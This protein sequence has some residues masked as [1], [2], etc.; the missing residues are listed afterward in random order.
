MNLRNNRKEVIHSRL[1]KVAVKNW[2]YQEPETEGFDPV[3]DLL[4][5]A[6]A[7]ELERLS[8]EIYDSQTHILEKVS[9]ILL[10]EVNLRPKP[11]YSIM[12]A[13]PASK[14]RHTLQTDQFIF[15]KEIT[16]K[17]PERPESK[18]LYFSP[19][20]GIRLLDAEITHLAT[21]EELIQITSLFTR[22]SV[23]KSSRKDTAFPNSLWLGLK[24]NPSV[25]SLKDVSFFIDWINN[26]EKENLLNLVNLAKW[27]INEKETLLK[28][29]YSH[30]IEKKYAL[31]TIEI[32]S[33]L[34]INLK[35]EKAILQFFEPHFFTITQDILP[36]KTKY[37]EEF[38]KLFDIES[39][40]KLKDELHWFRI[41]F[42][43]IFPKE[44]LSS[45]F[46]M[47]NAFPVVNRK[48]HDS[49]RPYSLNKDLNIIPLITDDYFYTIQRIVS[50]SQNQYNETP[51]MRVGEMSPGT[52]SVR[53]HGVKRFDE[54]NAFEYLMYLMELLR[55][56]HLAF[57]AVGSSLIEKEL[58]DL[59]VIINRL[60]MNIALSKDIQNHTHFLLVKSEIE[61]D[62][63]TEFWSTTGVLGNNLPAGS[64]AKNNDFDKKHLQLLLTTKGGKD[65]PDQFERIA[66]FKNELLTRNR[67]VTKDDIKTAC[68]AELGN[69]LEYVNISRIALPS[70]D[71][72]RGFQ[73]CI[74]VGLCFHGE[75]SPEEKE[76]M[77]DHMAKILELKS[78]CVYKYK[79]ES[80]Y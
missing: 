50:G 16:G 51:Y 64:T 74:R 49:N 68:F 20:A 38:Q 29:G 18:K 66:L 71:R 4:F 7:A 11:A 56:E 31:E 65:P 54:R 52:Y 40:E 48:F 76:N 14:E 42:P 17:N 8:S 55:E 72:F 21:H 25:T 77:A 10:P 5:G 70:S 60:R 58:T 45:T 59:Q 32:S 15:E 34:D 44:H 30:E 19:I 26:P 27:F 23:L 80:V 46:C 78:S 1:K 41:D 3:I 47:I 33:Y 43:E 73:N 37:P 22:E 13:K 57:E 75:K 79:V 2:G 35:T 24:I 62:I 6:C 53:S 67:I 36:A 63:W 61:E 39:L 12:Y 9:Q 69:E 28:K